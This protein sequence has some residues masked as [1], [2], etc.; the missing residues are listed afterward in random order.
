[1]T[2]DKFHRHKIKTGGS[3]GVLRYETRC[4]KLRKR[5][6]A[7]VIHIYFPTYI[8]FSTDKNMRL[9]VCVLYEK[10]FP[11]SII[12]FLTICTSE[13]FL[14][15]KITPSWHILYYAAL[16]STGLFMFLYTRQTVSS[17]SYSDF[18]SRAVYYV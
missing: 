1:V 7:M 13:I 17:Y 9:L 15:H 18:I 3:I 10:R 11:T 14:L 4:I 12:I 16:L 6:Q 2:A 5:K 8:F